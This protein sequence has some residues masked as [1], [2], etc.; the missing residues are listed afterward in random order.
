M[1]GS[2][3]FVMK[4]PREKPILKQISMTK[5]KTQKPRNHREKQSKSE[6]ERKRE[7]NKVKA[8]LLAGVGENF[9]MSKTE[10]WALNITK[11]IGLRERW[12]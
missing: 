1:G 7:Q 12:D 3:E 10:R 6:S 9:S 2:L 8:A 11:E 4:V 5:K